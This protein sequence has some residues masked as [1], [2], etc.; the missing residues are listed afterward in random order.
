MGV[1]IYARTQ[2]FS[3]LTG[4]SG[5]Q[6]VANIMIA[7]G[8][9]VIIIGFIGCC[10]AKKENKCLLIMVGSLGRGVPSQTSAKFVGS[11]SS[12]PD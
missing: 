9:L 6:T 12:E 7:A 3:S 8:A 5:F 2:D 4:D 1:G 11:G 10:G